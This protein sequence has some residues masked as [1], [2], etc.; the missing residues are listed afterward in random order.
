[1]SA[2]DASGQESGSSKGIVAEQSRY[3]DI[4]EEINADPKAP[5]VWNRVTSLVLAEKESSP[6]DF[7]AAIPAAE[8]VEVAEK[9]RDAPT[10]TDKYKILAQRSS[11]GT[12]WYDIVLGRANE[13]SSVG[14]AMG[15]YAASNVHEEPEAKT[16]LW[17]QGLDIGTGTGNSLVEMKKYTKK[18]VGIDSQDFLIDVARGRD[19]LKD[20]ELV[21]GNALEL[22]F[23]DS[24][25]D[26]VV[27]NGLTHY[28]SKDSLPRFV[29]EVVRVL[30]P[31]GSYFEEW[32]LPPEEGSI[33]PKV[34]EQIPTTPKGLLALLMDRQ[35]TDLEEDLE[36]PSTAAILMDEFERHGFKFAGYEDS[37]K[38]TYVIE[39]RKPFTAG[40][41]MARRRYLGV[42]SN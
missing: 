12:L 41:E 17:K 8:M 2:G 34:E 7:Y 39:F 20:T 33:L 1:M 42:V 19:E 38:G 29:G 16:H 5:S 32:L 13:M 37:E 14:D 31:G 40:M 28:I 6:Q 36:G 35:I 22:P 9:L 26:L 25:F 11:N 10:T 27:S 3:Q 21:V 4:I 15:T 30:E 24:T 23:I 18:A